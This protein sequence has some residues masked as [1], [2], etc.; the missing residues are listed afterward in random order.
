MAPM[1]PP[2]AFMHPSAAQF[3]AQPMS[4]RRM[5]SDGTNPEGIDPSPPLG[6]R[7]PQ[8]LRNVVLYGS[9]ASPPA[10]K[11]LTHLIFYSIQHQLLDAKSRPK[12]EYKKAPVIFV[13][14]R[15]VNDS[16][17]IVKNLVPALSGEF[18]EPWEAKITFELQPSIE[19]QLS[20]ADL[21]R[22]AGQPHG[23]GIPS[24]LMP[25]LI[26]S[27]GKKIRTGIENNPRYRVRPPVHIA[28]EFAQAMGHQPFFHGNRPGPVDLS[29]YGTCAP[30]Y[31]S[32]CELVIMM[33]RDARLGSWWNRMQS[34]VPLQMLFP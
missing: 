11:I 12:S 3:Q 14:G 7:C 25:L 24:F 1:L 16:F 31:I 4:Q 19:Y 10:V 13:N 27:I 9:R 28:M 34:M 22:W 30:F 5:L 18:N 8:D 20:P 17:I 6:W 26:G 32:G 23:F 33:L 2:P 29:F 15:Q 21:K